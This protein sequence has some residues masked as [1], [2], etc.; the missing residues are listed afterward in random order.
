MVSSQEGQ[1]GKQ[2][3]SLRRLSPRKKVD[4]IRWSAVPLKHALVFVSSVQGRHLKKERERI[5]KTFLKG[6]EPV[7]CKKDG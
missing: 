5:K 6:T 7:N 3:L 2:E 4:T 1:K